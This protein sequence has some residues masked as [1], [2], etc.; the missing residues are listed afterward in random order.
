M[1]YSFNKGNS[2]TKIIYRS[3][4]AMMNIAK[5]LLIGGK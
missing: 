4:T 5:I 3:I 1:V 2:D